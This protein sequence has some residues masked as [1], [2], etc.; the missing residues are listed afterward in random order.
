VRAYLKDKSENSRAFA[1]LHKRIGIQRSAPQN[2]FRRIIAAMLP[3][4]VFCF[5]K[6]KYIPP[7]ASKIDLDLL[8]AVLNSIILDWYFR[9]ISTNAMI[10]EYQF[11]SLPAPTFSDE[12]P[13]VDWRSLVKSGK[14]ADVGNMLCSVCVEPGVMH[15][16]VQDALTEMSRQ[17]Q[18]IEAARV[19]KNRSERSRLAPESQPIQN[20][21]DRILFR[22]YGL[23]DE[24]AEYISKRLQ[25]ML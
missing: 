11:N 15:K 6:L 7:A 1:H 2:N 21:I 23:S 10:N 3:E 22:C 12:G 4:G 5:D 24:E 25:E 17:I 8:I 16:P 19:L 14:W 9:L 13:S 18:K 20:T